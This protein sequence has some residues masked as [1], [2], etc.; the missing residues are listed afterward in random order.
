[1]RLP[2][3]RPNAAP[4]FALARAGEIATH[5]GWVERVRRRRGRVDVELLLD[6]GSSARVPLDAEQ[7]KWLE[8]EPGQI[9]DVRRRELASDPGFPIIGESVHICG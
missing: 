1:M 4:H 6:D 7:A 5:E 3:L 8:I 9:V 2:R